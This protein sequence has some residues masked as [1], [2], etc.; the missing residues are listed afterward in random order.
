MKTPRQRKIQEII[1]TQDVETQFELTEVLRKLGFEVTQA[2]VSRDI[3]ELGLVKVPAGLNRSKYSM[4]GK[5]PFV[6]VYERT[7]R[8]FMDNVT[9]MDFSENLILIRTLPGVAQA[10]ASCVDHLDWKEIIGTVAGDDTIMVV[11]KPKELVQIVLKRFNSLM[12]Q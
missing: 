5:I 12:N 4:P 10:V 11:V 8:M 9:N 2:T 3:K 7:K 1:E 6:N